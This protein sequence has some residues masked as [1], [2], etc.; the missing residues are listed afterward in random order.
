MSASTTDSLSLERKIKMHEAREAII[1]RLAP[2]LQSEIDLDKFFG[3]I[4]AELCRMM[5]V[6]C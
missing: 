5:L 3:A 1:N 2:D 6:E 4:V